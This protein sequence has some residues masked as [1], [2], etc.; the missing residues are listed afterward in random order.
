MAINPLNEGQEEAVITRNCSI[1]VSAP[2][3]S[4]KTKILVNRIMA[5]IEE[6]NYN[7]D[8]LLVLTFTNAAAL[9]MKQRLQS[10]LQARLQDDIDESLKQHLLKQ[11][12]LLAKAYITNFHGFCSTLLKQYG[13]LIDLNSNFEISSDPTLIKHQIL[14]HCIASWCQNDDF[15]DFV[16][17]YFPDHYFD[18]FKNALFK[19]ENLSNTIYDFDQYIID[20]KNDIYDSIIDDPDASLNNWP[21]TKQIIKI[22]KQQAIMGLNKAH[23]LANYASSH[24]LSFYYQNPFDDNPKKANL[25]SPYDCHLQYYFNVIKAIDSND[26]DQII[27]ASKAKLNRSYDS[28]GLFNDDNMPYKDEY[29]RLKNNVI[30]FYRDKFND[31]VYDDIDE[32][33]QV[34]AV[35]LKPLEKMIVYLKEFKIAYQSYKHNY[36]L[37]DFNDLEANALKLLEPQYGIASLLYLQLKEIMIDEYQDTNQIQETLIQKIATFQKPSINCF[38]VG[39]MKQSIYRFREADPEIF[40]QKYLTFNHLP[41]TKRIVLKFNYRS[42]K[43]VLDSV[44]Y[45]FNQIM[46]KDIG[47]LDYYLDDSAKLNYDYLRKEG[48]KE[49]DEKELVENKASTRLDQETRFTTEVLLSYQTKAANSD[50]ELE[51]KIVARKIQDLVGKLQLDNFDKTTRLANYRDIVILMRSTRSFIAFKKIFNRYQIPS[52][53]VLSQGFLQEPEIINIIHVLK[54]FNNHLDDIAFTSLLTGNYLYSNF[55]E[56]LIAAIRKDDSISMYDNV[57]NYIETKDEQYRRLEKFIDYYHQLRDYFTYHSVK[58]TIMKFITDNEYLAFL[59]SLINGNQRVAN[60]ELFIE[61]LDEMHDESLNTITN[62]FTTMLEHGINVSPAMVSSNDDNVVSFMTIH[63]SKGLEF[64]I[65]FVS[66]LQNKFNLQDSREQIIS[67][68]RLGIAIKPRL[69]QDLGPYHNIVIE[70]E[71]KYRKLIATCQNSEA[72]NEEMRIFY[73]ALTRAS[74]KLI[75]TGLLKNSDDI[76]KWQDYVINNGTDFISNSRCKDKVILYHNARKQNSYLDWLMI[77]LMS[78]DGIIKQGIDHELLDNNQEDELKDLVKHNFQTIMIHH[79]PN[80]IQDNTKHSKFA[81][82]IFSHDDIDQQI[83]INKALETNLD[84]RSYYNYSDFVYPY[85]TDIDKAIAVTKKIADGD[86]SFAELSYE[87]DGITIEASNRGTIIHSFLEHLKIVPNLNL[88]AEL[89]RIKKTNLFDENEWS[90]IMAYYQHLKTFVASDVFKLMAN[91]KYLYQEKEFSM[92]E[93]NQ[94][95]HGIFDVVCINDDKITV[96]DYKTD[97]LSK[98]TSE[99][100]LI[101][102]HQKQLEYYKKILAR[103]F[104]QK[105]IEALVYYLYI[106]RYVTF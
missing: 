30:K 58:D 86:R 101:S 44:N 31:L 92:Y 99:E 18:K 1:L 55:D 66:N 45:I 38:M 42:N 106:D 5:L 93:D 29:N 52:H 87:S 15:I 64:P 73:V 43:I 65:V 89:K 22:L 40:N 105:Q 100:A 95:I 90:V 51:A 9:E 76:V 11:Q 74:Q 24:Q 32:F 94:I 25:P 7:V 54:A 96:I 83:M 2:A 75:L 39:D 21:I 23:E 85:P 60:I 62:K 16:D 6:D 47:G 59:A 28:R 104:P 70:Y 68:K 67:D 26:I 41:D 77:S 36:N 53:I 98:H 61:K 79:S 14:D 102:L 10:A 48:A 84:L 63:K 88:D 91:S 12:Q 82:K 103:V 33:K 37:L 69:K 56:N 4:G 19:F 46:D 3:G 81:I 57:L 34:L 17:T 80:L 71:N 13:Y 20:I 8:Q 27:T 97:N 72:I 50:A 49:L 35:S 78:H